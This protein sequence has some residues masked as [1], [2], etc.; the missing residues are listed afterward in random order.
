MP[1][2]LG[3]LT[4]SLGGPRPDAGTPVQPGPGGQV[5][6]M[7]PM[8][9]PTGQMV[10]L[11]TGAP[12]PT[13]PLP[14]PTPLTSNESGFP[15]IPPTP[16]GPNPASDGLSLPAGMGPPPT[17]LPMARPPGAPGP[18]G[19]DGLSLP[20]GMGPGAVKAPAMPMARPPGAGPGAA[21]LAALPP[22]ATSTM[23]TGTPGQPANQ[24]INWL[25]KL[26]GV[27]SPEDAQRAGREISRGMA[28]AFKN[29]PSGIGQTKFA[30]FAGG[31]GAGMTGAQAETDRQEESQRKSIAQ[32]ILTK[33]SDGQQTL[34]LARTKLALE[35]AKAVMTGQGSQIN[36]PQQLYL[37]A[38]AL[39]NND[40]DVKAAKTAMEAKIK[41]GY[42][43]DSKEVKA[44]KENFDKLLAE[45]R[46]HHMGAVGLDP[47]LGESIGKLPGLSESTALT[48]DKLTQASYDNLPVGGYYKDPKTGE[49]KRK[50]AAPGTTS[51]NAV[52]AAAA[53]AGP[54]P[55]PTA[56][57]PTNAGR[58]PPTPPAPVTAPAGSRAA[59][60]DD[61]ADESVG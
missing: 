25:G 36:S 38:Q 10:P 48:G 47:K 40:Q 32:M 31:V 30:A 12:A 59:L 20:P 58:L 19:L 53:G 50:A 42:A 23:G 1:D 29:A 9:N 60:E 33:N 57:P 46:A 39:A 2:L 28:A 49:V 8:G 54:A 52:A 18:P 41:A 16:P 5:G 21:E 3:W 43:D 56:A 13:G 6:E 55:P 61:N 44:L 7:D 37:R 24:E 4:D 35:Q 17:P 22:G 11:P 45:R 15:A 34:N 27:K 51:P 26:M 14:A